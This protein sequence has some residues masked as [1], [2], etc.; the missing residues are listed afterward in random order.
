MFITSIGHYVPE[1]RVPNE[2]FLAINGLDSEWIE[3]RTGIKT[4]SKAA[5]NENA[6]TMGL[7][8][9]KQVFAHTAFD[10]QKVDLVVA[11][12]YTPY[13][14]V[15][16]LAH[17]AQREFKLENAK[18]VYLSSACSSLVN[19]LEVIEGYFASGKA[20]SALL[21]SSEHNTYYSNVSDPKSGHLWGDAAVAMLI[22]K[23]RF[24]PQDAEISQVYTR[25]LGHIGKGDIAVV[26]HP[27]EGGIIMPDGRDVFIHACRYMVDALEH[28]VKEENKTIADLD[29]IIC[30]Q[31]N[32]RIVSNVAHQ[33]R[34]S[35]DKFLNNIETY[36]N[37]GSA[38]TGLVLSENF[39]KFKPGQ[40]VGLCV[41]GGGYSSGGYL[42][43]F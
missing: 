42:V 5:S 12:S 40:L 28:I 38:S 19:A 26:L 1:E 16:T 20:S 8:A 41:F 31:A 34:L 32:K 30:H 13:D 43:K 21:I 37:T 10:T 39:A 18:S 4:R 23:E 22:T 25:G 2:S 17:I 35:D 3:Q 11:A 29:Y 6:H 27:K 9:C 33:L 24:T 36:G 15:A 7:E 14:T